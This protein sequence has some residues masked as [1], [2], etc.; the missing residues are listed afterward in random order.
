[1]GFYEFA[2]LKKELKFGCTGDSFGECPVWG[3]W[4]KK[5]LREHLK[6]I[7]LLH[8]AYILALVFSICYI[9]AASGIGELVRGG[10]SAYMHEFGSGWKLADGSRL[11]N[12]GRIPS[13][14]DGS[15]VVLRKEL[16]EDIEEGVALNFDSHNVYFSLRIGDGEPYEYH[17]E[18]NLTGRGYGDAFHSIMLSK[19]MAGQTV[20]IHAE[21]AFPGEKSSGFETFMICDHQVYNYRYIA[22]Y[23]LSAI[24]SLLII[25]FGFVV[26]TVRFGIVGRRMEYNLNALGTVVILLGGWTFLET[27]IPQ[28][29]TGATAFLR[30]LD[31]LLLFFV[32]YPLM[33]FINSLTKKKK[34]IYNKAVFVISALAFLVTVGIHFATGTDMHRL[35]LISHISYVV[36][37]GLIAHMLYQNYCYCKRKGIED[38]LGFFYYGALALC[39]GGSTDLVLYNLFKKAGMKSG[40]YLR[41]GLL[42]FII[43]MFQQIMRWVSAEQRMNK[44]DRFI[45]NLLQYSMSGD[46][47]EEILKQMLEYTG[48]EMRAERVYIFEDQWDGTFCNTYEW[49]GLAVDSVKDKCRKVPFE[50]GIEYWYRAFEDTKCVVIED[51]EMY[52]DIAGVGIYNYMKMRNA[53]TLAVSPLEIKGRC[54]GF[55]GVD[56]PPGEILKDMAESMRLLAYFVTEVLRQRDDQKELINYSYYDQMTGAKNRRAQQEFL[57]SKLD[58]KAP[59]GFV[60]CDINGLKTANDTLGHEEGDRMICDVAEVLIMVFGKNNVYRLGGDEFSAFGTW[61]T[62]AEFLGLIDNVRALLQVKGRS[63]SLGCVYRPNGDE[64]FDSVKNEADEKMYAD[65]AAFYKAHPELNRRT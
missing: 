15:E 31:Y 24:L 60:M 42:I 61:E 29:L 13:P 1:M 16:P 57:D 9:M 14:K 47:P 12:I 4:R 20:E 54:I 25:F 55:F 32:S 45:N 36:C 18:E 27:R 34:E 22:N 48:K 3:S 23:G 38:N 35:T 10:Q 44:R 51:K 40:T 39:I 26:F 19:E 37:G 50:G 58:K 65:K 63:A 56:D 30:A 28:L 7:H 11:D 49:C 53:E 64:D 43:M 21:N 59:Y 2:G 6:T 52:N 62:E 5:A 8:A 17:M 33:L 41:L 46:S